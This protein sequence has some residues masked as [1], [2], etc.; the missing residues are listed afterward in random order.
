LNQDELAHLIGVSTTMMMR[1]E[2]GAKAQLADIEAMLGLEFVFGKPLSE[3]FSGLR[4]VVEE[5]VIGR[6][7]A[8]EPVWQ[9]LEDGA[10]ARANLALLASIMERATIITD[11]A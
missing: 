7:A 1:M 2:R 6:A 10:K 8:L 4:A 3:I 5:A 11:A 9:T